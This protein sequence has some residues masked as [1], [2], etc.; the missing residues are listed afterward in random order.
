MSSPARTGGLLLTVAAALAACTPR[1]RPEPEEKKEPATAPAP[2]QVAPEAPPA[3]P[4]VVA[5]PEPPPKTRHVPRPT[6]IAVGGDH[7]CALAG[8]G[9]VWCWGAG[10]EG[11][12]GPG[13]EGTLAA[14]ARVEG[15]ADAV[16]V[17]ASR[18]VSC[19]LRADR[20]ISCWGHVGAGGPPRMQ[21]TRALGDV[22][23]LVMSDAYES[24]LCAR[25][26][27][28]TVACVVAADLDKE[29]AFTASVADAVGVEADLRQLYV[30]RAGGELEVFT[31]EK[32]ALVALPR[33]PFGAVV[34]LGRVDSKVCVMLETGE[35]QCR[36]LVSDWQGQVPSAGPMWKAKVAAELWATATDFDSSGGVS[37]ARDGQGMVWCWGTNAFGQ[38]GTG[39]PG[40]ST[41]PRSMFDAP[42]DSVSA[43]G[44][45]TCALTPGSPL[46]CFAQASID[47]VPEVEGVRAVALSIGHNCAIV[48]GGEAR[49]WGYSDTGALGVAGDP[50]G[51]VRVPDLADLVFIGVGSDHS[52]AVRRDDS[53]RCWG[54]ADA[55]QL[56][57]GRSRP[58]EDR[59]TE[60]RL[61]S[62]KPLR[63]KG[64]EG[65]VTALAVAY[66]YACVV[67][68]EGLR[69]W[70]EL[71]DPG[72]VLD[73]IVARPRLV[74]PG[75]VRAVDAEDDSLCAID[76]AGALHCWG[77][78]AQRYRDGDFV[79]PD[80]GDHLDQGEEDDAD[81]RPPP[82][83]FST[84]GPLWR[85]DQLPVEPV[86]VAV[87]SNHACLLAA[88]GEVHC[89]GVNTRG[90][91][92]DGTTVT[93]QTAV[94]VVG[95]PGK[96]VQIAA[97]GHHSCARLE[98][99]KILCW[100]GA[101][102]LPQF[103]RSTNPVRVSGLAPHL[104]AA[105]AQ[106]AG[107]PTP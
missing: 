43:G 2:A 78:V 23:E 36:Y 67:D 76:G 10:D 93:R 92:G 66:D 9:E 38:L 88:T 60:G 30:L 17:V 21:T 13:V 101:T 63:V 97:G 107:P 87:G 94:P 74:L 89:W 24:H 83:P 33:A 65:P 29:A 75:A 15:I 95:L 1:N 49:C 14:P 46:R 47:E 103:G 85:L 105:A 50:D 58:A 22:V 99:G 34:D 82:V 54:L 25:R 61:T 8:A 98:D 70:G 53:V 19:A 6:T 59:D 32:R 27:D 64:I 81:E 69:C 26:S 42:A 91:V 31:F 45:V 35:L 52:C 57:D 51:L 5:P 72:E 11:Q 77:S 28:G 84:G 3:V 20:A 40:Y 16:A 62:V 48:G 80:D 71:P 86:G 68:R 90:Q 102:A 104:A 96:A 56:G 7:V 79:N 106:P 41:A 73:A 12:L 44:P 100:G 55:G 39:A 4:P 37:C 18:R